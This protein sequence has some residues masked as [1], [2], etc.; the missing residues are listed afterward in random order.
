LMIINAIRR[1]ITLAAHPRH[2]SS[3]VFI[4]QILSSA[5]LAMKIPH[6]PNKYHLLIE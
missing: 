1:Q 6:E 4:F 5:P 2:P 3:S